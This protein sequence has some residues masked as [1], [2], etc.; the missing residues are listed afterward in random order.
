VTPLAHIESAALLMAGLLC[1][2]IQD[3]RSRR[4]GNPVTAC[5]ALLGI[6]AWTWIAGWRG[7][8]LSGAGLAACLAVGVLPF[9]RGWLG[10]GD[11]KLLAASGAWVGVRLV[12]MLV[13]LTAA[14]GGLVSLAT[15]VL[16]GRSALRQRGAV[17]DRPLATRVPYALAIAAGVAL[18]LLWSGT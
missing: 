2:V 14:A 5:I 18:T 11:V 1:A 4:V 9:A 10:A 12:P 7:F 15:L 6:A 3:L 13:L 17:L 8:L 16:A